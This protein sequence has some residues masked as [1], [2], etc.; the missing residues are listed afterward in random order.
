EN[1]REIIRVVDPKD[2]VVTG[3]V[4]KL[5]QKKNTVVNDDDTKKHE[6]NLLN[7]R[8]KAVTTTINWPR[9]YLPK[10]ETFRFNEILRE[11]NCCVPFFLIRGV[12]YNPS[13]V[14]DIKHI[15]LKEMEQYFKIK[16]SFEAMFTMPVLG[17]SNVLHEPKE[18]VQMVFYGDPKVRFASLSDQR[19]WWIYF[20]KKMEKDLCHLKYMTYD[21]G[22]FNEFN[23]LDIDI[24]RENNSIPIYTD[25]VIKNG[26]SNIRVYAPS[27]GLDKGMS[28]PVLTM[29]GNGTGNGTQKQKQTT[30]SSSLSTITSPTPTTT[31]TT[32][33]DVQLMNVLKLA[34]PG[35]KFKLN[36]TCTKN[37]IVIKRTKCIFDVDATITAKLNQV[38]CP[39][40]IANLIFNTSFERSSEECKDALCQIL[41][42]CDCTPK[43]RKHIAYITANTR[44]V[45]YDD[46][47][48]SLTYE[49]VTLD[50]QV[51]F[52]DDMNFSEIIKNTDIG[53]ADLFERIYKNRYLYNPLDKRF[54]Y[55]NGE[56]WVKDNDLDGFTETIISSKMSKCMDIHIAEINDQLTRETSRQNQDR[57]VISSLTKQLKKC[58]DQRKRLTDGNSKVKR[59]IK[60][61]IEDKNFIGKT[62]HPGKIAAN[63][64]LVDLRTMRITNFKPEDF[65]TEKCNFDYYKCS[66]KPGECFKRDE[67][68]NIQCDSA[69]K[70]SMQAVDDI[71]REIMGCDCIEADGSLRF[72]DRLYNH[73]TRMIGYSLTGEGNRKW[74]MYCHSRQNSGKSLLLE[75]PNDLF[76]PYY[77]VV[78]K[79]LL[80]GKKSA[81]G[82]TPEFVLVMGKRA[83]F[84]DEVN[85]DD[86][87]DD[88]NTKAVTGRSRIE[89]RRMGGEYETGKMRLVPFI[90]VNQHNEMDCMDPAFWDRLMPILF[91]MQFAREKVD[92]NNKVGH[93]RL[94]DE[95][96]AGKFEGTEGNDDFQLAYFNV[97]MRACGYYYQ[98]AQDEVPK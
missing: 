82:P 86:K 5:T 58:E 32:F 57:A 87:F 21:Q 9:E 71:I 47:N 25:V 90:G 83:G 26:T 12:K 37:T 3:K 56:L 7:H 34:Y 10:E 70:S 69:I 51:V 52:P 96:I 76:T 50:E 23:H 33:S 81:N 67:Y 91:P 18:S 98:H 54:Y 49:P 1:T 39:H 19:N 92:I 62:V 6:Q 27:I 46:V 61:K 65:I 75:T 42:E 8:I 74:F 22:K 41:Y 95:S 24:Y 28:P 59:F 44:T 30:S 55:Y 93:L 13:I 79:G 29:P 48:Q 43:K 89:W 38:R 45:A 17:P 14:H 77:C 64:G 72:G 85:K 16:L 20:M 53:C 31:T 36:G 60:A 73:F 15:I 97:L 88:R 78:P 68:N 2:P 80:F 11:N 63:N 4:V 35:I 66:C 84:C 40:G 94:R